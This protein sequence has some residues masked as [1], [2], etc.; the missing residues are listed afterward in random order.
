MEHK[1][2][3]NYVLLASC[4]LEQGI[5]ARL[6]QFVYDMDSQLVDY[7]QYIDMESNYF[8]VRMAWK[9]PATG[10]IN[11]AEVCNRFSLQF[12]NTLD[13]DWFL[14]LNDRP[15]RIAVFVTRELAHLY[16]II[17][18]CI[19]GQWDANI[20]MIISNHPDLEEE[21]DRFEI[22]YHHIPITKDNKAEQE[23]K[24]LAL[25][26]ENEIDLI[27]LSRYMQVI[28][29]KLIEPYENQIIN[30]H[31]SMLPAFAG[32]KP[33][34]QAHARGVKF[35]GATSHYVTDE[36]DEG[37]I[38]VQEVRTVDHRKTVADLIAIGR[39]LES[40]A[41]ARA[42]G[43]HIDSRVFVGNGRTIIFDN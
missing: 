35:I 8:Y 9:P 3:G 33:Y 29:N 14:R 24:H 25:I 16:N 13:L 12:E 5:A 38:I 40:D 4:P 10:G 21:A 42:V 39:D 22:P 23:K 18:K 36:L 1:N 37:P 28:S 26:K 6:T 20:E 31:H 19:S 32:A 43:L 30:I 27:V 7:D 34:H 17:M 11:K 2:S 41:L 15:L